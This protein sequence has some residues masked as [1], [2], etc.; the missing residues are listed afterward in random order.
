MRINGTRYIKQPKSFWPIFGFQN[1]S[2]F[3]CTV[4]VNVLRLK[5]KP[6]VLRT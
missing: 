2:F 4:S 1:S 5:L 3:I 6:F